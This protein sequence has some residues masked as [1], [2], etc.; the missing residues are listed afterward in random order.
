MPGGDEKGRATGLFFHCNLE[1]RMKLKLK[2]S[3]RANGVQHLPPAVI[4]TDEIGISQAEAEVLV[5]RG[6]AEVFEPEAPAETDEERQA[7]EQAEAEAAAKAQ[8]EAEPKAEPE[9]AADEADPAPAPAPAAK[10]A[11]KK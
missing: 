9:A 4:D 1:T 6:T 2:E 11:K 5:R 10:T 8:A 3:I 7:R